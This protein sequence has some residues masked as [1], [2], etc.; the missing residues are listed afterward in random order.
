[1]K[2]PLAYIT[3]AASE[4]PITDLENAINYSRIVYELGFSPICPLLFM[5]FYLDEDVPE[6]HKSRIDMCKDFLRRSR[7]VI[8]CGK[9]RDENVKND[10][11]TAER[12][13]ITTTTLSGIL[14][15]KDM[16]RIY[17]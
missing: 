4:E 14:D 12:L 10:I 16:I 7:V 3:F 11:A 1:M 17:N 6:E 15:I 13:H 9:K 5:P 2:R 8:V